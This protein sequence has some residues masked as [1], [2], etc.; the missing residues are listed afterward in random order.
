[1]A[2]I[3]LITDWN[4]ADYYIGSVKGKILSRNPSVNIVDIT[5]QIPSF[6]I[7]QAAF[8]LRNCYYEFPEGTVHIIGISTVISKHIP[9]LIVEKE[10]HYFI[11]SDNGITG[12]LFATVPEK[13]YKVKNKEITFDISSNLSNYADIALKIIAGENISS[14][15]E[16]VKDFSAHIPLRP[17]IEESLISGSVIYI[18]SFSNVITNIT[19]ELFERVSKKRP[20]EILIQSNQNKIHKLCETYHDVPSGDLVALFNSA[21]LLEIA[22]NNGNAAG[23]LGLKISSTVRINFLKN[24]TPPELR[25]SGV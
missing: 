14:F 24:N 16:P 22:I 2:I 20:F 8:I 9:L 23:L 18:D 13:V 1:M 7:S 17:V 12:L 4:K 21:G 19:K 25:L 10:G 15:A 11:T 5:H 6:N 3:T